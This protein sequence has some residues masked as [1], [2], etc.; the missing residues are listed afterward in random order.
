M[1]ILVMLEESKVRAHSA[2]TKP[3]SAYAG[4]CWK[5]GGVARA[6][7]GSGDSGDGS[8]LSGQVG[9]I[10]RS[11]DSAARD[12]DHSKALCVVCREVRESN[13][14]RE[15]GRHFGTIKC[16]D[17]R[18]STGSVRVAAVFRKVCSDRKIGEGCDRFLEAGC[19]R[20]SVTAPSTIGRCQ[21]G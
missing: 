17:F 7:S 6:L 8:E 15:D 10:S 14:A 13:T 2:S 20:A 4:A 19:D 18:P 5:G 16:G 12:F 21:F 9:E 1:A 11:G 3:I